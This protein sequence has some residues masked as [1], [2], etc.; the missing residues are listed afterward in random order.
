MLIVTEGRERSLG[1]YSALL[2]RAG[3][4]TVEGRRTSAALDAILAIKDGKL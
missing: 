2:R 4:G 3:F 1:E